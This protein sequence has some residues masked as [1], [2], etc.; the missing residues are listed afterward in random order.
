MNQ[1]SPALQKLC[2]DPLL[3]IIKHLSQNDLRSL[4]LAYP[5]FGRVLRN[6]PMALAEMVQAGRFKLTAD[7]FIHLMSLSGHKVESLALRTLIKDPSHFTDFHLRTMVRL[8]PKLRSLYLDVIEERFALSPDAYS[9][10]F[11]VTGLKH[12]SL[13][14]ATLLGRSL[15]DIKNLRGLEH[16]SLAF[17]NVGNKEIKAIRCCTALV[18]LDL[19]L[20]KVTTRG[21]KTI[22]KLTAL[23]VLD[24]YGLKIKSRGIQHIARKLPALESITLFCTGLDDESL[25]SMAENLRLRTLSALGTEITESGVLKAKK[26]NA[27]LNIIWK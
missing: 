2:D 25:L 22:G 12:L 4:F 5:P 7:R 20:T 24:L 23:R 3:L 14:G 15:K 16:L 8:C 1:V 11:S 10:L 21:A 13:A 17:T 9:P 6:N 26:V 19:S 27:A 18:E